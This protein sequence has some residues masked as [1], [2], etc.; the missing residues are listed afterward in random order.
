MRNLPFAITTRV[1]AEIRIML[2]D[3][4]G[5]MSKTNDS[6]MKWTEVTF[7]P[8]CKKFDMDLTHATQHESVAALMGLA[9][10]LDKVMMTH[11]RMVRYGLPVHTLGMNLI[12]NYLCR[13]WLG[14]KMGTV[15]YPILL[16]GLEHKTTETN[17]RIFELAN[18]A[19]TVDEVNKIFMAS[20]SSEVYTNLLES[21]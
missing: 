2:F 21:E 13:R 6:Y 20:Q 19:R 1:M 4:D 3:A 8:Y 18:Q 14:E 7:D 15:L 16:S 17:N 10:E 11:F 12:T 9:D 5:G